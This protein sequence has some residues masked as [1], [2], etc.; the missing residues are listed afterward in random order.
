MNRT[1]PFL[2]DRTPDS[3]P[4]GCTGLPP[5][6]NPPR[7]SA[8]V[9]PTC[10]HWPAVAVA[11][12]FLHAGC[13]SPDPTSRERP[14]N[15]VIASKGGGL[16]TVAPPADPPARTNRAETDPLILPTS[17]RI[18]SVHPGLQFVVVDYTLGGIPS[19]QSL[20]PVYR[21]DQKVGQIRLTGPERNGFV[22]A[23]VD[24]GLL[25]VDDEVRIH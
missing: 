6:I 8:S 12:L 14:A 2:T 11:A 17:G 9:Q 13:S 1:P 25:Q 23:D 20:L 10:H 24:E 16:I 7:R 15:T 3:R 21:G 19:F 18:H 22:A 4:P 5:S